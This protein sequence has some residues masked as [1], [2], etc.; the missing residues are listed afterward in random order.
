MNDMFVADVHNGR[1][2]H[3]D[4]TSDRTHLSLPPPLAGK[5]IKNPRANGLDQIMFGEDFG[6]ITHLKIGPDGYLYVVSVWLGKILEYFQLRRNG[7][8]LRM[9]EE[10]LVPSWRQLLITFL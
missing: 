9:N 1:I 4:L 5:V 3:F 2:Y 8:G 7:G 10:E 6:G